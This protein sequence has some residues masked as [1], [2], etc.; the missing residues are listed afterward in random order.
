MKAGKT[1]TW[2]KRGGGENRLISANFSVRI[3]VQKK[4]T[5]G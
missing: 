1:H 4:K 3:K 5:E 2:E